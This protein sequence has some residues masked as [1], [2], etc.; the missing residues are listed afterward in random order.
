MDNFLLIAALIFIPARPY[1]QIETLNCG[2]LLLTMQKKEKHIKK[3]FCMKKLIFWVWKDTLI[4]PKSQPVIVCQTV[5]RCQS[6]FRRSPKMLVDPFFIGFSC[7]CPFSSFFLF[8]TGKLLTVWKRFLPTNG[9]QTTCLLVVMHNKC[10]D[11]C[12]L[13][14]TLYQNI[15]LPWK[16]SNRP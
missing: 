3:R 6:A 9:M 11:I 12:R 13:Y 1:L 5:F 14:S 16:V 2:A 10:V 15:L 8:V 7:F 4:F